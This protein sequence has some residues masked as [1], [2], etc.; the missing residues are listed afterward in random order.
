MNQVLHKLQLHE[1]LGNINWLLQTIVK[2]YSELLPLKPEILGRIGHYLNRCGPIISPQTIELLTTL[3]EQDLSRDNLRTLIFGHLGKVPGPKIG[4]IPFPVVSSVGIVRELCVSDNANLTA[5][6]ERMKLLDD[7]GSALIKAIFERTS[8]RLIWRPECYDFEILDIFGSDD[9]SVKGS[10]MGLPLALA[11]CSKM[12]NEPLPT[13]LSATGVLRRDGRVEPV[14]SIQTKLEVLKRERFFVNRVLVS[15]DQ[16][17]ASVPAGL[18]II[19][20]QSISDAVDIVFGDKVH[21]SRVCVSTDV[22]AELESLNRQYESYL[23]DTCEQNASQLITYLEQPGL[24]LPKDKSIRALFVCYWRKG[25]CHCHRG[26]SDQADKSLSKAIRLYRRHPGLIRPDEYFELKNQYGVLL[27]DLFRYRQAEKVHME[28]M[29]E[30]KTARCLDHTKGANLSSLSQLYLAQRRFKDAEKL[31]R[32]AIRLVRE[33]ERYRNYGYLTQVYTRAGDFRRASQALSLAKKLFRDAPTKVQSTKKPFLDWI[34]VEL[35]YW[36]GLRSP[37]HR[38]KVFHRLYRT[39]S[40]YSE[41]QGWVGALINKFCA[42]AMLVE[43][44]ET[45]G[46]EVLDKVVSFFDAQFA[47]VLR[48]LGASVKA[49]KA[50]Y[51]LNVREIGMVINELRGILGDLSVQKDI[52]AYFR[53]ELSTLSSLVKKGKWPKQSFERGAMAL[54]S[55]VA[56][57]PY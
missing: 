55:I 30:M 46:L 3:P 36:R 4:S 2:H 40:E 45:Q 18:D 44:K 22:E 12:L 35:L 23:I 10:S 19:K 47:P 1:Q 53:K 26:E 8:R 13:D 39:A 38:K 43:G 37:N 9:R 54:K 11:L 31:Q 20:V 28:L 49:Q 50:I 57:I 29:E 51:L 52:Q 41:L 42:L 48:V 5:P 56:K 27:K 14:T 33:D 7:V 24:P 17:L 16:E 15:V 6:P 32:M 34:E 25:C 21:V